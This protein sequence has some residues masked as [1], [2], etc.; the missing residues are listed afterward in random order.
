MPDVISQL[1]QYPSVPAE[2]VPRAP[3]LTL[4]AVINIVRMAI[5]SVAALM[6]GAAFWWPGVG[7]RDGP[8]PL[9]FF[10]VTFHI[11][12][13]VGLVCGAKLLTQPGAL[14]KAIGT[15]CVAVCGLGL[16]EIL[17]KSLFLGETI[18]FYSRR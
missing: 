12:L 5:A 8:P 15:F 18:W 6:F 2:P 17:V 10:V 14:S 4:A 16:A 9:A 13:A 7:W 1:P 11:P 3:R